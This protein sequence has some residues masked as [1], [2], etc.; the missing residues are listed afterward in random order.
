MQPCLR[1]PSAA[2]EK[3]AVPMKCSKRGAPFD[4]RLDNLEPASSPKFDF[5]HDRDLGLKR[6][7]VGTSLRRFRV[8]WFFLENGGL[9]FVCLT[10]KHRARAIA[11]KDGRYLVLDPRVARNIIDYLCGRLAPAP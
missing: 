7:F 2:R 5:K 8:G 4:E 11:T 9:A 6:R 1:K 3:Y 10:R